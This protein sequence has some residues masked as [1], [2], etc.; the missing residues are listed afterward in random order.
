MTGFALMMRSP[1]NVSSTRSTPCVDG[2]CGP[3]LISISWTSNIGLSDPHQFLQHR[4]RLRFTGD[5]QR[6]VLRLALGDRFRVALAVPAAGGAIG[7]RHRGEELVLQRAV[8]RQV[9][10]LRERLLRIVPRRFGG[11]Y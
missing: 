8:F 1:S 11:R 4:L 5:A 6:Q 7:L 10:A 3:K 2:C 9:H